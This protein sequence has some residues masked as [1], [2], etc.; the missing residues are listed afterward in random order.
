MS[1][2]SGNHNPRDDTPDYKIAMQFLASHE[3]HIKKEGRTFGSY[4]LPPDIYNHFDRAKFIR[5]G[6]ES[7]IE[8]LLKY[9]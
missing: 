7:F 3:A 4:D 1:I 5:W 6:H 2:R 9:F 8:K